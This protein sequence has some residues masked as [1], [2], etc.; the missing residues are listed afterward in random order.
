MSCMALGLE[1]VLSLAVTLSLAAVCFVRG[2][3]MPPT[4]TELMAQAD[5]QFDAR[6]FP[7]AIDLYQQ[8]LE[9]ATTISDTSTQLEAMAQLARCHLTQNLFDDAKEWLRKAEGFASKNYPAGYARYLGVRGRLEWREGRNDNAREL[10]MQMYDLSSAQN[11]P[12]RAIDAC[13][14][15]AIVGTPQEQIDWGR[16]GIAAAEQAGLLDNLASL[17]NNL[18]ASHG[19]QGDYVSACDAFLKAREYHWRFGNEVGK[20]YAD[21]QVGWALRMK[22]D[23]DQALTWLRPSLAWAERLGNDDVQA[24]ACED[25]GEIAFVRSDFHSAATYRKRALEHFL[26]A[27]YRD[28]SPEKVAALEKRINEAEQRQE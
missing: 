10:F 24:Q 12:A 23:F 7:A 21:Y 17:W 5:N 14:M 1:F 6:N 4:P 16:R 15:M 9:G 28:H 8:A 2:D 11:L 25:L 22:G 19:D 26:K 13:R 18:A 27:G 3:D 20:L